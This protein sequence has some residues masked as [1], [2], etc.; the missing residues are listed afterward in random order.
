MIC[1]LV[2]HGKFV[3]DTNEKASRS[4]PS[5]AQWTTCSVPTCLNSHLWVLKYL[6]MTNT[7]YRV[8]PDTNVN[9]VAKSVSSIS[10]CSKNCP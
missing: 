9:L 1:F 6:L 8:L 2:I 10:G 5:W 3:L 7:D 4:V